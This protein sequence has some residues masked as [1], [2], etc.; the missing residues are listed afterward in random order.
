M[1]TRKSTIKEKHRMEK[2][3]TTRTFAFYNENPKGKCIGDCVVRAIALATGDG[4]DDTYKALCQL[5]FKMKAMPN[6]KE[7][8]AKYLE[9]NGWVK[10][11]QPRKWDNTKYTG[12]E[13][14]EKLRD[15]ENYKPMIAHIGGHHIVCIIEYKVH[16]IWDS[17]RG[18]IGNYWTKEG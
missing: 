18:C 12:K 1:A 14:C 17:T 9:L 2:Y 15:E 8:Y 10:H 3:P 13:W 6:D 16:D 7:V 5:G 4:W 11:K